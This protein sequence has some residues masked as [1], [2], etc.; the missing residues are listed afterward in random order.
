MIFITFLRSKLKG[1]YPGDVELDCTLAWGVWLRG[2][3]WDDV[4]ATAGIGEGDLV[5]RTVERSP[6][7]GRLFRKYVALFIIVVSTAL[8]ASGLLEIWFSYCE[9]IVSLA[10]LQRE[11]GAS[12]A[13]KIAQFID[14]IEDQ[15][16]WTTQLP[17]SAESLDERRFD[18]LRLLRQVPAITELRQI[19]AE[20]REQLHVSRLALDVIGSQ[21]DFS[22]NEFF[23]G[24][25]AN[26]TYFGPVYFRRESEPYV[27]MAQAGARRDVGVAIAE[28]NLKFIWDLVSAIEVGESGYAYVVDDRGRLVAHPDISLVLRNTSLADLPQVQSALNG[29]PNQEA[30]VGIGPDGTDVISASAP[31]DRLGWR[32]FVELPVREA[33][34][35]IYASALRTGA[36][37]LLGLAIAFVAGLFLARRMIIP[38]KA[39][40]EGAGRLGAGDLSLRID[41]KTHDEFEALATDFND[42]ADQLQ[43]SH[44]DLERRVEERTEDLGRSVAEL[45]ALGEVSQ[46]VSSSLDLE[47]VLINIVRQAVQLSGTDAGGIHEFNEANQEFR[48]TATYG[49]S[50][51]LTDLINELHIRPGETAIGEATARRRPV[52]IPDLSATAPSAARDILERNGYR[53]V[54]AVPLLHGTNVVGALVVRR[55]EPGI[56]LTATIDLL[57]TFAAHSVI[58][59]QNA[60]LFS[61]LSEKS[62]QLELASQHKSQ[63]LANMSH[64]LRTPLNAVLGYTELM[65]DDIYG[66]VP[67]KAR[68]VLDRVQFN[69]RH[70]LGLINNVL[71]LSKIEAGQIV[72][73]VE[74]FDMTSLVHAA[75]NSVES[76]AK[77]K[78]IELRAVV[79][80]GLPIGRGDSQR[81]HQ[82][83]V[84]LVGNAIKF[85]EEGVVEI[86]AARAGDRFILSVRDTGPGIAPADQER[87]FDEFQQIDSSMTRSKGGTGLGLAITKRIVEMHGGA[88]GVESAPGGGSTFRLDLPVNFEAKAVA[89]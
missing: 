11:Q 44:A 6:P 8:A 74:P 7:R 76:L 10:R 32:V 16:G 62:R 2:R 18:A 71:D 37:L 13:Y 67:E 5:R 66:P 73:N 57:Q 20:G 86:R 43:R 82:V 75:V 56:F 39:L 79:E 78:P 54:L 49:S 4:T 42:M 47:T 21:N 88:I 55:T 61:E 70:L 15:I 89:A 27:T 50:R 31:I 68:E 35:P 3:R 28:V 36:L 77:G 23:L 41:V 29:D 59:M 1:Y 53:A 46:A 60:R 40:Q 84:N 52:Q 9:Q 30:V 14:S 65:L 64:E 63:F 24:A 81:L 38:I 33:L 85:T 12:A 87:I 26:Q 22:Q 34:A 25:Q 45:K 19:D 58:A 69:G 17:W 83:L 72:L 80:P 51:E 48:L